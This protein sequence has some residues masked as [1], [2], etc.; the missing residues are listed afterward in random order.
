MEIVEALLLEGARLGGRIVGIDGGLGHV[1]LAQADAAALLEVDGGKEP[2]GRHSRKLPM[3]D[4]P[5]VWLF[6]GWNCVPT[7]VSRAII[8]VTRVP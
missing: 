2:H 5:R 3:S 7:I 4:R 1:A 8:A 6:S